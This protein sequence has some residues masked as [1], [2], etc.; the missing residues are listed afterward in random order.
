[1][2]EL[3]PSKLA[4]WVRFPSPAPF[5]VRTFSAHTLLLSLALQIL[6][7]TNAEAK[8]NCK[9]ERENLCPRERFSSR[10]ERKACLTNAIN[11]L[12]EQCRGALTHS[13]SNGFVNNSSD[14]SQLCAAEIRKFC[15]TKK[16]G[17]NMV[18]GSESACKHT[19]KRALKR[20]GYYYIS[21]NCRVALTDGKEM[22]IHRHNT[23]YVYFT[24]K[25]NK[26]PLNKELIV[27]NFYNKNGNKT[28]AQTP[29][30]TTNNDKS[31]AGKYNGTQITTI[32]DEAEQMGTFITL[33]NGVRI[34]V[35]RYNEFIKDHQEALRKLTSAERERYINEY[36][37][38]YS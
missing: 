35:Y 26:N 30:Q 6:P 22:K 20:H 33:S 2:V 27:D 24:T 21:E 5:F 14:F 29:V 25:Q 1:M 34:S 15:P 31:I 17:R 38:V 7:F 10:S 13:M 18:A 19:L 37:L 12:P 4:T 3:Q 32:K 36:F 9:E 28:V 11:S 8:T 23:G 16:S